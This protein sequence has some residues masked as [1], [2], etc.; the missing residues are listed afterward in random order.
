R[1]DGSRRLD[2]QVWHK[3]CTLVLVMLGMRRILGSAKAGQ[4]TAQDG[5]RQAAV[6]E[7][8]PPPYH[9]G[10]KAYKDNLRTKLEALG[11]ICLAT[12]RAGKSDQETKEEMAVLKH[13]AN[14]LKPLSQQ[15][16]EAVQRINNVEIALKGTRDRLALL[17]TQEMDQIEQLDELKETLS[18]IDDRIHQEMIDLQPAVQT[19]DNGA[20]MQVDNTGQVQQMY[21]QQQQ[22]QD[23]IFQLQRV[24]QANGISLGPQFQPSAAGPHPPPWPTDATGAVALA[25]AAAAAAATMSQQANVQQQAQQA[26]IMQRQMAHE[27]EQRMQREHYAANLRAAMNLAAD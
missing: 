21:V 27:H 11:S 16:N 17:E 2:L 14:L 24:I 20:T 19:G 1:P 10:I 15:R 9:T 5:A 22:M 4:I 7:W 3:V 13:C 8:Q 18:E 12:Q 26:F 25:Q 6:K 23:T